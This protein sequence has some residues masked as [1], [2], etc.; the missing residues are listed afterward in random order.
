MTQENI[1]QHHDPAPEDQ[2]VKAAAKTAGRAVLWLVVAVAVVV[3]ILG[4]FFLGP[5]GLFILLPAVLAIWIAA[6]VSSAGPA[7]GA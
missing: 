5:L 2:P 3:V 1:P 7:T 6:G 4:V